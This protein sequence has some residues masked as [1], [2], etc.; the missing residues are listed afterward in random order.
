MN[1]FNPKEEE[2]INVLYWIGFYQRFKNNEI[3]VYPAREGIYEDDEELDILLNKDFALWE[4]EAF[5]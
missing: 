5:E 3:F 1:S 4:M 2:D